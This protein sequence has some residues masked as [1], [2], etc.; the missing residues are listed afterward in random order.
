[1]AC[2]FQRSGNCA[3]SVPPRPTW[4]RCA[5]P[6]GRRPR[7]TPEKTILTARYE[8]TDGAPGRSLDIHLRRAAHETD[9]AALGKVAPA[10]EALVVY[11]AA[12]GALD[13]IHAFQGEMRSAKQAGRHGR[14]FMEIN[15]TTACRLAD[16]PEGPIRIDAYIHASDEIGWLALAGGYDMRAS[17]RPE[18]SSD[19]RVPPCVKQAGR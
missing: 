18:D 14:G 9:R 17:M 6:C 5:W 12:P 11:E 19:A 1:M 7:L 4:R 8:F 16:I 13:A 15:G 3:A 10:P 2:R